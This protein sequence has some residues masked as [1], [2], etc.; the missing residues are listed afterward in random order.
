MPNLLFIAILF[1]LLVLAL[2]WVDKNC[3]PKPID[4]KCKSES[5]EVVSD[6]DYSGERWIEKI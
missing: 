5:S 3:A 2:R 4:Y 1:V 6:D